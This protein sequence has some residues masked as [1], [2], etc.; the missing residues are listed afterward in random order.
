MPFFLVHGYMGYLLFG[1]EGFLY[2]L[3]PDLGF[4][5]YFSRLFMTY[6]YNKNHKITDIISSKKMNTMDWSLYDASHSL[7]LWITLLLITKNKL[8]YASIIAV[9]M[10]IFLH[11]STYGGWRG[12]KFL[13]PLS[14]IYIEGI[15]WGS[16][17][18]IV[19]TVIM[20]IV[21]KKN[22]NTI[23]RWID[24]SMDYL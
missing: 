5:P 16:F 9:L 15:H 21:F 17:E 11:S 22:V 18:G 8:F 3:L 10:D 19:I 14:D 24:K 1:K 12:P 6:K 7:V 4:T 13:Y 20:I 23:N 2:G